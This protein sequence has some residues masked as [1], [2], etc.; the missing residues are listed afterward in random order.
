MAED[1]TAGPRTVRVTPLR[2]RCD[3]LLTRGRRRRLETHGFSGGVHS[4]MTIVEVDL[5]R[6]N[7]RGYGTVHGTYTSEFTPGQVIAVTDD[8]ADALEATVIAVRP[9]S[10]DLQVHWDRLRRDA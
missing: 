1:R 7:S 4:Q 9:G 8:D 2:R 10:A 6:F 3:D 5:S